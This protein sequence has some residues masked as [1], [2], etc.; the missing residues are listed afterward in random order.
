MRQVVVDLAGNRVFRYRQALSPPTSREA[1]IDRLLTFI[2]TGLK[3]IPAEFSNVQALGVDVETANYE[4][5]DSRA[6]RADS[7]GHR[8]DLQLACPVVGSRPGLGRRGCGRAFHGVAS[9]DRRLPGRKPATARAGLRKQLI[10]GL[11]Q[12][13]RA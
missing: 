1:F 8:L 3:K 12:F 2:E 6:R 5:S 10:N 4:L 9:Q 7:S 11:R 13:W